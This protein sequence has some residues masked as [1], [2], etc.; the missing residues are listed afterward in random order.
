MTLELHRTGSDHY[1]YFKEM[2][3]LGIR[4]RNVAEINTSHPQKTKSMYFLLLIKI[5]D[6][7][8]HFPTKD[9]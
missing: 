6:L 7:A 3:I 2:F 8:P 4:L 5:Q 1:F 9:L